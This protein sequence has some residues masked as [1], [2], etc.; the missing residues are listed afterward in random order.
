M[1]RRTVYGW[2]VAPRA[3]RVEGPSVKSLASTASLIA[4]KS[5]LSHILLFIIY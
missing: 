5:L 4:I 2:Q 1:Q 3:V